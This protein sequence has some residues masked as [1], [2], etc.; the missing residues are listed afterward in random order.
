MSQMIKKGLLFCSLCLK[1][2]SAYSQEGLVS[3][4]KYTENNYPEI[5]AKQAELN[6]ARSSLDMKKDNFLPDVDVSYDVNYATAN[7]VTGMNNSST[8]IGISGPPVQDPSYD[9]SI[10]SSAGIYMKWS[11]YTFGK[12]NAMVKGANNLVEMKEY[13]LLDKQ[14]QIQG[15]VAFYYL[16]LI[17]A[18]KQLDVMR[19]NVER[20]EFLLKKSIRLYDEGLVSEVDR[21]KFQGEL[22]KAKREAM[23]ISKI[24]DSNYTRLVSFLGSKV[25]SIEPEKF[26]VKSLPNSRNIKSDIINSPSIIASDKS[27][28]YHSQQVKIAKKSWTPDIELWSMF[29]SR[30]SGFMYDGT[31]DPSHGFQLSYTNYGVGLQLSLSLSDFLK[32]KNRISYESF[33]LEQELQEKELLLNNLQLRDRV[34]R[35]K[36]RKSIVI[37]K[38]FPI[39][40]EA[41]LKAYNTTLL[42]Y[43]NGL[44]DYTELIASQY[45]L[46]NVEMQ[47]N[48]V[49]INAWQALLE[50]SLVQ[51]DLSIFTIEF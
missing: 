14:I 33:A 5:L 37:A 8:S 46:L 13:E 12:R 39:E 26:F 2:T 30:G 38:G 32:K 36:Y 24:V 25:D 44:S 49:Y 22:A 17:R 3:L 50:L 23:E 34:A 29:G 47:K 20:N 7:N 19:N 35:S 27:I 48:S 43:E 40:Y 41:Y 31:V 11:P 21:F 9:G 6:M 45:D 4:M 15:S 51:G 42:Q 10:G 18:E 16:E 1:M 28:L